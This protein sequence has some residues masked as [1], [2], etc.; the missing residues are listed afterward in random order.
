MECRVLILF[1]TGVSCNTCCCSLFMTCGRHTRHTQQGFQLTLCLQAVHTTASAHSMHTG[2]ELG[3]LMRMHHLTCQGM[4]NHTP[5]NRHTQRAQGG[6]C[7]QNT[8]LTKQIPQ[9]SSLAWC[10]DAVR[11]LF[12]CI[13][14]ESTHWSICLRPAHLTCW[15]DHSVLQTKAYP[16]ET[17]RLHRL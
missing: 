8:D 3:L 16:K 2:D 6:V 15:T 17:S 14:A 11:S 4:Q 9:S 10:C 13:L 5:P 12:S 7:N 1:C